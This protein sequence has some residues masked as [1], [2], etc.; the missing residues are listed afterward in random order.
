MY[1]HSATNYLSINITALSRI[2]VFYTIA[3]ELPV[4][5]QRKSSVWESEYSPKLS[6]V[7][8]LLDTSGQRHFFSGI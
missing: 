3:Q 7:K 1:A 8:L 4:P 2:L 5:S 6:P